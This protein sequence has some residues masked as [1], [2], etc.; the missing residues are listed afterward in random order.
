MNLR[1]QLERSGSNIRVVEIAPPTVSRDLHRE[2]KDPDDNKKDKN[3]AALSID[4]FM[5]E[6][7][8]NW[9]NDKDVF[10]AGVSQ[11]AVEKWH[12]AFLDDYNKGAR[13]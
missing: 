10:G 5:K 2:R 3:S 4:E 12:D 7:V 6:V 9:E 13:A 1:A 11:D 8:K